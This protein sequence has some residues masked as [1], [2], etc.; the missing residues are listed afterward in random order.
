MPAWGCSRETSRSARPT[1]WSVMSYSAGSSCGLGSTAG[2][3]ACSRRLRSQRDDGRPVAALVDARWGLPAD[4]RVGGQR[5][6]YRVAERPGPLAMH[7]A[8]AV[9]ARDGGVVE[10]AVELGE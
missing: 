1:R 9:V 2:S 5:L 3:R 4:E 8:H 7:D 6:T 10:V